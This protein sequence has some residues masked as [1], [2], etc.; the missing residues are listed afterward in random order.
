MAPPVS[1]FSLRPF[2]RI[3]QSMLSNQTNQ[4]QKDI[5][6]IPDK[7]E[8]YWQ[9]S[10]GER[11]IDTFNT[12]QGCGISKD[13]LFK[14]DVPYESAVFKIRH[15]VFSLRTLFIWLSVAFIIQILY[16][17]LVDDFLYENLIK[18]HFF[19]VFN[20]MLL[21]AILIITILA[22]TFFIFES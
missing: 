14:K 2:H 13:I 21:P 7:H 5:L 12:C 17:A 20:R 22:M 6:F 15:L 9:C 18:N 1:V 11:Q 19:G 8:H 16:E 10:C 4:S 3:Y